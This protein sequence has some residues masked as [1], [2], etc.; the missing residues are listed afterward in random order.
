ML[1]DVI[2]HILLGTKKAYF[3]K[4]YMFH[5]YIYKAHNLLTTNEK[6]EYVLQDIISFHQI[7]KVQLA[8][9]EPNKILIKDEDKE[10]S[11][12]S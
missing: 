6:E 7:A 2:Q 3:T 11:K 4:V 8:N 12:L 5:Y 9:K 1:L 10:M